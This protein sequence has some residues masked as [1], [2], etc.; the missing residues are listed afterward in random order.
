[1][2]LDRSGDVPSCRSR[3][4]VDGAAPGGSGLIIHGVGAAEHGDLAPEHEELD[5]LCGGRAT[6]QQEQPAHVLEDQLQPPQRHGGDHARPLAIT[7]HRWSAVCAAFW[8]PT[9]LF[10]SES[11]SASATGEA[12]REGP[13]PI[14]GVPSG[15]DARHRGGAASATELRLRIAP[16]A[17][18]AGGRGGPV[19]GRGRGSAGGAAGL[20][21]SRGAAPA[22]AM[23]VGEAREGVAG[24]PRTAET[25]WVTGS[26]RRSGRGCRGPEV[27][28][29]EPAG[30]PV[31]WAC[32]QYRA[33]LG[34]VLRIGRCSCR[35]GSRRG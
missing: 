14:S 9:G 24:L 23:V 8:N 4:A 25:S 6:H 31:R 12:Q 22:S 28:A 1:V 29:I 17:E 33:R 11:R 26:R 30:V 20:A 5:V 16:A 32:S 35:A 10:G 13:R 15:E 7:H 3:L 21:L 27:T 19:R 2:G 34:R 18:L